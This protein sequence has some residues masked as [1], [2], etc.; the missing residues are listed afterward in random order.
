MSYDPLVSDPSTYVKKRTLR[1]DDSVLLRHMDDVVGT[2]PDEQL[3]IG[4]WTHEELSVFDGCG[5]VAQRRRYSLFFWSLEIT[6]TSRGFEVRNITE[7]VESLLNLC[8]MAPWR[9]DMLNPTTE[10]KRAVKTIASISPRY[11]TLVFVS[12]HTCRF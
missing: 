5:G 3:M 4:F 6:K 9:P 12:N 2:G 10:S 11:T 7:L 8:G 1:Q